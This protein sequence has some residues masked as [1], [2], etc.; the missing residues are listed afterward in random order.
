M[1][2]FGS[3]DML[4]ENTR[5]HKEKDFSWFTYY[6]EIGVNIEQVKLTKTLQKHYNSI[7]N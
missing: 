7:N 4:D 1:R 5:V 3:E 6:E 2:I